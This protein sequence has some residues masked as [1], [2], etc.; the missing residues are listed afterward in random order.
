MQ[1]FTYNKYQLHGLVSCR[2]RI[3]SC[4]G[5]DLNTKTEDLLLENLYRCDEA[6]S[7]FETDVLH[8]GKVSIIR[9][10]EGSLSG[11]VLKY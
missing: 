5:K 1:S 11:N 6:T 2:W 4:I 9:E 3:V 7:T 10:Q 8:P